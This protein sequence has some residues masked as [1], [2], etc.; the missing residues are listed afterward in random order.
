MTKPPD[1]SGQGG[2]VGNQPKRSWDCLCPSQA[3]FYPSQGQHLWGPAW[4]LQASTLWAAL[5]LQKRLLLG[6]QGMALAVPALKMGRHIA[7]LKEACSALAGASVPHPFGPVTKWSELATPELWGRV[8]W[9][10]VESLWTSPE[11]FSSPCHSRTPSTARKSVFLSAEGAASSARHTQW[12]E[13]TSPEAGGP[14]RQPRYRVAQGE[15]AEGTAG[16]GAHPHLGP[17]L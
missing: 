1:G 6:V 4:P 16:A 15:R 14:A 7:G 8:S 2:L 17:V 5:P 11:P 9:A 10:L 12:T 13:G 3:E